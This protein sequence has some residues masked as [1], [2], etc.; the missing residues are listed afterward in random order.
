M[1][2]YDMYQSSYC[3]AGIKIVDFEMFDVTI[4]PLKFYNPM[5]V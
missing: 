3:I 4:K 5:Y 1:L 2:L